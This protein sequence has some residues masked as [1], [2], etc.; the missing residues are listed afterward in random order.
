M[1]AEF[2]Q[3][4]L[5]EQSYSPHMSATTEPC[6]SE[7]IILHSRNLAVDRLHM[8]VADFKL[9]WSEVSGQEWRKW[10]NCTLCQ[11]AGSV[12]GPIQQKARAFEIKSLFCLRFTIQ[13]LL[14]P[15]RRVFWLSIHSRLFA[16]VLHRGDVP[17]LTAMVQ[18]AQPRFVAVADPQLLTST[19]TEVSAS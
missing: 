19:T 5:W 10:L 7:E 1:T 12:H 11:F 9:H 18:S 14:D 16:Y 17:S 3:S 2:D 6:P 13:A 15:C 4:C 8:F